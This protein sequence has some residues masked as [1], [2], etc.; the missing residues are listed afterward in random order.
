MAGAAAADRFSGL[1][2]AVLVRVVSFL[3]V[4]DAARTAVLS[5]RWR[6][7]W[8]HTGTLNLDTRSYGRGYAYEIREP[9]FRDAGVAL[10]RL[11][12]PV[13]S[14]SLL[15]RR[16]TGKECQELIGV[17]S[18]RRSPWEYCNPM[19]LAPVPRYLD[20][21]LA[22]P[23]LRRLEELRLRFEIED[24]QSL[25]YIYEL[26]PEALP[27]HTLRALDLACCRI[28][29]PAAGAGAAAFP[30]LVSLRLDR[31]SVPVHDLEAL[32]GA[33]P[34]LATL[35]I[36]NLDTF[37]YDPESDTNYGVRLALHCPNLT[38]LHM[39]D[40]Y[41]LADVAAPRLRSFSYRGAYTEF[42]FTADATN[43]TRADVEFSS[44]SVSEEQELP[45][46]I[47]RCLRSLR[48]AK[49]LKLSVVS[50]EDIVL[51][52]GTQGEH[53][54]VFQSLEHLQLEGAVQ[55]D[56]GTKDP[57]DAIAALLQCCPVIHELQLRLKKD[58]WSYSER[59]RGRRKSEFQ[60]SMDLFKG[61]RSMLNND[62]DSYLRVADLQGLSGCW[63]NCLHHLKIVK[64]QFK[65]KEL[66]SFEVSLAKFFAE[67]CKVLE[68]MQIDDG[69]QNFLDHI[70][71]RIEG[72]RLN[73]N[74][75]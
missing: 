27:G 68:K 16:D 63:F 7:L 43:L 74:L 55:S 35:R 14:L 51:D 5:R 58:R 12:P 2:D 56:H 33:A 53:L 13:R 29:M 36:E 75:E 4:R 25:R 54:V 42:T 11:L 6:P 61:R 17:S 31:C 39:A 20:D 71:R 22:D 34:N 45:I 40:T 66:D 28:E 9:L 30:R 21:L 48:H 38:A 37:F 46:L 15:A 67:N 23:A 18:Y 52:K 62:D 50:L 65:L 60:V 8:L 69:K 32:T 1:P 41:L 59:R 72:W 49:M 64:L 26:R 70:N 10:R 3:P 73:A 47:W 57:A 19:T 44:Y 24:K